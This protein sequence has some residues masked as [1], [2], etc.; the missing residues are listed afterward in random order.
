MNKSLDR[1]PN[2]SMSGWFPGVSTEQIVAART[3]A[4]DQQ[5]SEGAVSA[6]GSTQRL[7]TGLLCLDEYVHPC[8]AKVRGDAE[9]RSAR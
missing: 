6:W 2:A 8:A 3:E 1:P 9:G 7:G 4:N 5:A